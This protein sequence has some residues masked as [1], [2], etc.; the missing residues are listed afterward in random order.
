MSTSDNPELANIIT[1]DVERMLYSVKANSSRQNLGMFL[2]R[3]INTVYYF[4]N[5]CYFFVQRRV[6]GKRI[7]YPGPIN[8]VLFT[9][10]TFILYVFLLAV[11]LWRMGL[12]ART[13]GPVMLWVDLCMAVYGF[14]LGSRKDLQQAYFE[15]FSGLP[16]HYRGF[17]GL[18]YFIFFSPFLVILL[19]L[20]LAKPFMVLHLH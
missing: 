13:S 20:Y 14:Y 19:S 2:I 16:S 11:I 5:Y 4:Y 12:H 3:K 15:R 17:S 9:V 1:S 6:W 8:G 7:R 18:I 10:I